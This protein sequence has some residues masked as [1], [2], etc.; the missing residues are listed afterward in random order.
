[1]RYFGR[2]SRNLSSYLKGKK[3]AE[4]KFAQ[5][6][7]TFFAFFNPFPILSSF[8]Y[9]D[10][11]KKSFTLKEKILMREEILIQ[12]LLAGDSS[13]MDELVRMY[14]PEILRYCM[15]HAPDAYLAEDA[16]QETFLKAMKYLGRG[17][18]SG[19]F[20]SFLYK[21]AV[22]TCIDMHRN[23]WQEHVSF[24][25][26]SCEMDYVET[27]FEDATDKLLIEEL[28][29]RLEPAMQEVVILRFK[30][31]LKLR[32]I[33]SVMEMPM[34]TVQSKLRQALKVI[35]AELLKG[36]KADGKRDRK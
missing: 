19:K 30:Q 32:E 14:Y 22:N 21:I 28:V 8:Y 13:A 10:G 31:D 17:S 7:Q 2:E 25:G 5:K 3:D 23:K 29:R 4:R 26:I 20:R 34:R 18:F 24:E 33:A 15:W 11:T 36:G 6:A 16:A 35:K 12:N 1:M 27:G 9:I